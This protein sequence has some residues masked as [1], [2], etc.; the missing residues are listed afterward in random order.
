MPRVRGSRRG[1]IVVGPRE[2]DGFPDL[3]PGPW[4][5][6]PPPPAAPLIPDESPNLITPTR[7]RLECPTAQGGTVPA[8]FGID[9]RTGADIIYIKQTGSVLYVCFF[10]SEG[11]IESIASIKISDRTLA[12]L[13]FG[14]GT[15]YNIH[16]GVAGDTTDSLITLA[17][18]SYADVC[19][20]YSATVVFQFPLPNDTTGNYNPFQFECIVKGRLLYDPRTGTTP[21][22]A[23][24][25]PILIGWDWITNTRY[26]LGRPAAQIRLA[27]AQS[28]ANYCDEDIDPGA[29]T[30]KRW[31]CTIKV[32]RT[33]AFRS[34]VDTLRLHYM[35][36]LFWSEE[37]VFWCDKVQAATTVTFEDSG[38][39]ANCDRPFV[40]TKGTEEI[41]TA[42]IGDW[43]D[44]ANNYRDDAPI[45]VPAS[46]GAGIEPIVRRF[47]FR[48]WRT[49][50]MVR[51]GLIRIY[52]RLH[53]DK[54]GTYRTTQTALRVEP[55]DRFFGK[56]RRLI[57]TT[58]MPPNVG[59]VLGKE[60]L[61][62]T[63]VRMVGYR[64]EIDWELYRDS[65]YDETIDNTPP[66]GPVPPLPDPFAAPPDPTGAVVVEQVGLGPNGVPI[67]RLQIN[68]TNAVTQFYRGT[69]VWVNLPVNVSTTPTVFLGEFGG[70]PG[71]P[72]GP[73]FFE[74][75]VIGVL[76]TI[77]LKTVS[78]TGRESAGVVLTIT[79]DM[80]PDYVP[81]P[82]RANDTGDGTTYWNEPPNLV[83]LTQYGA[84]FWT[85]ANFPNY[86][87]A[88]VND[89]DHVTT[90]FDLNT[91]LEATLT[92]DLG[93]GNSEAFRGFVLT[94]SVAFHSSESF[95]IRY[96]D[97]GAIWTSAPVSGAIENGRGLSS[98]SK[99]FAMQWD[100]TVGAHRWWQYWRTSGNAQT[101]TIT[102][103]QPLE[104]AAAPAIYPYL[105]HYE[106][107]DVGQTPYPGVL[108]KTVPKDS[109]PTAADPLILVEAITPQNNSMS[110]ELFAVSQAGARSAA[111]FSQV[112]A[113]PLASAAHSRMQSTAGAL[114]LQPGGVAVT[115]AVAGIQQI[116]SVGLA[117][118]NGDNDDVTLGGYSVQRIT[119]PT[120]AYAITGF[121]ASSAKDGDVVMFWNTVAQTLTLKDQ[122]TGSTA[123]NRIVC[124][125]GTDMDFAADA[126]GML[127]YDDATDR[128]RVL[129]KGGSGG[130]GNHAILS[131]THTDSAA[132][133]V[134][135]GDLI[136]GNATPAWSRLAIGAADNLVLKVASG[137]P[138]WGTVGGISPTAPFETPVDPGTWF[139]T[140]AGS[141]TIDATYGDLYLEG[142][143]TTVRT[144]RGREAT[145]GSGSVNQWVTAYVQPAFATAAASGSS[146][147][148]MYA[149]IYFRQDQ[150]ANDGRLVTFG[151]YLIG[152]G[153]NVSRVDLVIQ[154]YNSAASS[155]SWNSTVD[156]FQNF[157]GCG[158][159]PVG[160]W[161]RMRT[162]GTDMVFQYSHDGRRWR[163]CRSLAHGEWLTT[164]PDR[165]G[166]FIHSV[167]TGGH[168]T[169]ASFWHCKKA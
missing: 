142:P 111:F 67:S 14:A 130:G 66:P 52:D 99:Q 157:G 91:A 5:D 31:T 28:E 15:H 106:V 34:W 118:S 54:T 160:F 21:A 95:V 10:V 136:V 58:D 69:R 101:T 47:N 59:S 82:G 77:T 156:A 51:R 128:W 53:S 132:A 6:D 45:Q 140:L 3:P 137:A 162:D 149:G 167:A 97:D 116:P 19:P 50:E 122:D 93:V 117:L 71:G 125:G 120:A 141:P 18:D 134:V 11:P 83:A 131:A 121:D 89:G 32:D 4:G 16:L 169:A 72:G 96:S 154:R 161:L 78:T 151:M 119:G 112:T 74:N 146:M 38:S 139:N 87:G 129:E 56:S 37:F 12:E 127:Q 113:Q 168:T 62:S 13:G 126:M 80:F 1:T 88:E 41:P 7:Q 108:V 109:R 84:A 150:G 44:A 33:A 55:G 143:A 36:A 159:G 152:S 114:V 144:V 42:V 17:G 76:H 90:A 48:G 147:A 115:R 25:N 2:D 23:S 163:T 29:G 85:N 61:V 75:P 49:V 153:S 98:D 64:W 46:L 148:D 103:L 158:N 65:F 73:V 102:E 124:P 92:L 166:I 27:T 79:P 24:D 70:I 94:A 145:Y 100:A 35:G 104:L 9:E 107:R 63:N 164:P 155:Y 22:T 40:E 105:S 81:S 43:T 20:E 60:D 30:V 39:S 68:W 138:A 26:G 123:A 57:K 133:S 110:I 8:I 135:A 165:Y 86:V